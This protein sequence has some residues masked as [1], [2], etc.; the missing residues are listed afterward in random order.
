MT[1]RE[2]TV[3]ENEEKMTQR[4]E[5][6]K[7]EIKKIEKDK[8]AHIKSDKHQR[9][10]SRD[11]T[12]N[13][14]RVKAMVSI[15]ESNTQVNVDEPSD[16]LSPVY[17]YPEESKIGN[18]IKNTGQLKIGQVIK[19]YTHLDR[20]YDN[21]ITSFIKSCNGYDMYGL[22]NRYGTDSV[23]RIATSTNSTNLK[24]W[25]YLLK[26]NDF[27]SAITEGIYEQKDYIIVERGRNLVDYIK[28]RSRHEKIEICKRILHVI[29]LLDVNKLRHE[30]LEISSFTVF[31]NPNSGYVVRLDDLGC[32]TPDD[33]TNSTYKPPKFTKYTP[34]SHYTHK[35][36]CSCDLESLLYIILDIIYGLKWGETRDEHCKHKQ[37]FIDS[38]RETHERNY[39]RA[40]AAV[41]FNVCNLAKEANHNN[42][43]GKFY[44]M[45]ETSFNN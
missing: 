23:L 2:K 14:G 26:I 44:S 18:K 28:N 15:N 13:R 36:T 42:N 29:D 37:V 25:I 11:I 39:G 30:N 9:T 7:E 21:N 24:K 34:Y 40:M 19:H 41:I 8:Q 3:S 17:E 16:V 20:S 4:E 38:D 6:L 31:L 22:S 10:E 35:R 43:L 27:R 1:Q 5:I 32:M 33:E 12:H 45:F